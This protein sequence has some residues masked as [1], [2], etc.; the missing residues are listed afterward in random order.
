MSSR[1]RLPPSLRTAAIVVT[2]NAAKLAAS[3]RGL[4]TVLPREIDPRIEIACMPKKLVGGQPTRFCD[5]LFPGASGTSNSVHP[6]TVGLRPSSSNRHSSGAE[7]HP[8]KALKG[9]RG[10]PGP[11]TRANR[12]HLPPAAPPAGRSEE[13]PDPSVLEPGPADLDDLARGV[14][15]DDRLT[16]ARMDVA[17]RWRVGP[18]RRL[19]KP[20]SWHRA[21]PGQPED[22]DRPQPGSHVASPS[23][24]KSPAK[25]NSS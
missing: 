20:E 21:S 2:T 19:P 5:T 1:V 17:S 22:D 10:L 4:A 14:V 25:M 12:T 6:T 3:A 15:D 23:L 16:R 9:P 24:A 18:R 8:V 7:D 11:P 13:G